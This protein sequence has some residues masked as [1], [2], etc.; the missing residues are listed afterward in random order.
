M[1]G[2]GTP[3]PRWLSIALQACVSVG[4]I[5]ALALIV[6]WDAM[7][8]ALQSLSFST[9]VI[10]FAVY[11]CSQLVMVPRWR[12]LISALG[13]H[14]ALARSWHTIF[15]GLFLQ[16][17]LPGSLG[18][19]GLRVIMLSR[20]CGSAATAVGAIIFDRAMQLVFYGLL[21]AV[22]LVWPIP[23]LPPRLHAAIFVCAVVGVL[24]VVGIFWWLSRRTAPAATAGNGLLR[25]G[26]RLISTMMI[27][28]GRM[29]L[30]LRRHRTALIAFWFWSLVS[31]TLIFGVFYV[32]LRDMGHE[33]GLPAIILIASVSAIVTGIPISVG[34][35][36]P[37][38]ATVV[39]LFGLFG[40]PV[41]HAFL[42]ALTIRVIVVAVNLTG[43]PSALLLWRER[44]LSS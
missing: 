33:L 16:N 12:A 17:F 3:L 8:T 18:A 26:V 21:I 22:V 38:E 2:E 34:G 35:V 1:S 9:V 30:R 20:A 27:E 42:M 15:G 41:A 6:D 11:F 44:R 43:L 36:G 7:R 31:S 32:L 28:T 24:L 40:V 10:G 14:E 19:D 4:L 13:V 29:Q 25:R 39:V 23:A 37:Y 5:I